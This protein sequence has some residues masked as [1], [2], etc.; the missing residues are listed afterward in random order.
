L[1]KSR[2]RSTLMT[3]SRALSRHVSILAFRR[4]N[5]GSLFWGCQSAPIR[6]IRSKSPLGTPLMS[7]S[8]T[9]RIEPAEPDHVPSSRFLTASTAC[10]SPIASGF[11]TRCRPWG[12]P[13]FCQQQTGF[14]TT[15]SRPPK[16]SS[17]VAA[18]TSGPEGPRIAG[19][20]HRRTCTSPCT[21]A[22]T[23]LLASSPFRHPRLAPQVPVGLEA[24]LHAG[25][26]T[27]MTAL[28]RARG[29]CFPGLVPLRCRR[30]HRAPMSP[31]A[32]ATVSH[33]A[34]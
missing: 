4:V 31:S 20:R 15:R 25:S 3:V 33:G 23:G 34:S 6:R 10:S 27:A 32:P 18:A 17:S 7:P 29:P 26:G 22:F 5:I 12:S 28:P 19:D 16:P 30:F 8:S 14:L 21:R 9:R 13:C 1:S 2:D 11:C 24:L